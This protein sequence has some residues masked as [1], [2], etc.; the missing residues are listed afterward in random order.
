MCICTF[1][2][3]RLSDYV[4][5]YGAARYQMTY[6]VY[7]HVIARGYAEVLNNQL[8]K[9]V[10]DCTGANDQMHVYVHALMHVIT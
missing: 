5:I 2:H 10:H 3:V 4:Y 6:H 1:L 9:D 8:H 7:M